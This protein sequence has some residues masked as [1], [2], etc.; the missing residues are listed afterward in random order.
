MRPSRVAASFSRPGSAMITIGLLAAQ[1]GAGPRGILTAEADVD[2]P[3]EVRRGELRRIAHV[4]HLRAERLQRQHVIEPHRLH[5]PRQRFVE[6]RALLAVQHRVVVEV[7]RRVGL[8]GGDQLDECRLAHR[9]QRVVRTPLLADGR[10]RLLAQRL[11]AE[12]TGAVRGVDQAGVGQRH[13][14]GPQRVVEHPAKVVG[15]PAE[16][17]PQIRPADV[18]DEQRVAGEDRVRLGG[19]ALEVVDE[20][21]NRF[22]GVARRLERGQADLAELDD[23]A[24]A[25]RRERVLRPGPGAEIDGDA[26]AVAQ[27]EVSGDEVGVKVREEDVRDPQVVLGR[28]GEILIDVALRID[29]GC[30][31]RAGVADEVRGVRQAIQIELL[32]DHRVSS[33]TESASAQR[34]QR[35]L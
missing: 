25:E 20:D 13:E 18:A 23:I 29:D 15:G 1:D 17:H 5:L 7:G 31:V 21:G 11:A 28:E 26:G 34:V 12:R 32:Q 9:L 22:G 24:V 10:E 27:L 2:A 30:G 3:G 35:P 16:R 6:R 8:I 14:L 19:A 33:L 4:E